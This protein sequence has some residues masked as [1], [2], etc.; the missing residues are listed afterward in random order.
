[1]DLVSDEVDSRKERQRSTT[2]QQQQ[3]QCISPVRCQIQIQPKIYQVSFGTV[4]N[5]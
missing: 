3:Q 1:M 2:E 4:K 5:T